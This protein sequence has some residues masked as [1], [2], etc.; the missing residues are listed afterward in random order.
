M[1]TVLV[2]GVE[3][4]L[5]A[6]G[7]GPTLVLVHGTG[8]QAVTWG[9]VVDHLVAGGRQV[10]TYDRR[11]FGRSVAPPV[12][13]HRIHVRDLAAVLEHIGAPVD[14][15]GWSSGGN[16]SLGL[17]VEHP[18]L[19][20]RLVVFEPPWHGVR[21]ASPGLLGMIGRAKWHQVTGN[22]REG[23]AAFYRWVTGRRDGTNSYDELTAEQ[24]EV[25]LNNAPG[26]L[27]D[28]DPHHAGALMEHVST[29]DLDAITP[30]VTWLLGG[31]TIPWFGKLFE[32]AHKAAPSLQSQGLPDRSHLAFL[33]DPPGFA[34]A[35]LAALAPVT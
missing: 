9:P 33:E 2:D 32:K 21:H 31:A 13:D 30:P 29:R 14:V 7:S 12:R 17:A 1:D 28:L 25:L 10:I 34:D 20:K 4:E 6:Q 26:I 27:A 15:F 18:E 16:V 22:P 5:D 3:F 23:A 24:Q 8:A 35:V 19:V 11:G